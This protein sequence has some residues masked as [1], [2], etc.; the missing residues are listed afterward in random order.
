MDKAETPP[1]RL[2]TAIAD[3]FPG[4]FALVMATGIVSIAAFLL[5]MAP[6][7]YGLLYVNVAAYAV[8][9]VLLVLRLM[10]FFPRVKADISDHVRG[11]GFFTVAAAPA[12]SGVNSLSSAGPSWSPPSFGSSDLPYG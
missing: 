9:C 11:P 10:W 3:L 7:A 1:G 6:I 4:Y 2:T 8:L 12:Y 5:G